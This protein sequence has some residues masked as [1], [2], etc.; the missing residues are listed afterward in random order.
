MVN[1]IMNLFAK[2]FALPSPE[3][4]RAGRSKASLAASLSP[5]RF[6][7]LRRIVFDFLTTP[8]CDTVSRGG[9]GENN[10]LFGLFAAI[11]FIRS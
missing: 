9:Q 5:V 2:R 3:R 8:Y 6:V 7:N 10:A 1:K 11:R 4:L